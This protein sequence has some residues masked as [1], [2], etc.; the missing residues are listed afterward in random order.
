MLGQN[1]KRR[2]IMANT[3][4][5]KHKLFGGS[6][7]CFGTV[8]IVC[9]LSLFFSEWAAATSIVDQFYET[10]TFGNTIVAARFEAAQTF[11]VGLSGSMTNVEV[12]I[13]NFQGINDPITIT[14]N[15][16]KT[17]SGR[18]VEANSGSDILASMT[19]P[20]SSIPLTTGG[21]T[22]FVNFNLPDFSVTSGEI[23]AIVLMTTAGAVFNAPDDC[24]FVWALDGPGTY[25]G[26]R[27]FAR[28]VNASALTW[29]DG[30]S[31]SLAEADYEFRTY[32]N[33]V[34]APASLLLL[35]TGLFMLIGI[36]KFF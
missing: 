9:C 2:D 27:A 32:V 1:D 18:P 34:P 8:F 24:P 33:P 14:L 15:I 10:P 29:G 7:H 26:G 11:T 22:S 3:L 31:F 21:D 5:K 25:S 20:A 30:D 35:S 17:V 12:N 28:G 6:T 36:R 13:G 4:F 23:L 16:R 19:L